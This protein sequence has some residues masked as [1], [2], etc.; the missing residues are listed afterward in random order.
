MNRTKPF[1]TVA[2][3]T[4]A[5]VFAQTLV[6]ATPPAPIT[7]FPA[8]KQQVVSGVNYGNPVPVNSIGAGPVGTLLFLGNNLYG[9]TESGG[10]YGLGTVFSVTTSGTLNW[11]RD[12]TGAVH[13]GA[14]PWT[15][16][17]VSDG[18]WLYGTTSAGGKYGF[19]VVFAL[20][21][22]GQTLNVLH[23]FA[24][25]PS[26]GQQPECSLVLS[27]GWLYGT[28]STGGQY[29]L[30]EY[31]TVFGVSTLGDTSGWWEKNLIGLQA[32]NGT[33]IGSRPGPN[34]V[35]SGNV[36][37][38][39][40]T[41]GD[42]TSTGS[43]EGLG[44]GTVFAISTGGNLMSAYPIPTSVGSGAAIWQSTVD[45][46]GHTILYGTGVKTVFS[47]NASSGNFTPLHTFSG[48]RENGPDGNNPGPLVWGGLPTQSQPSLLVGLANDPSG[49]T[50]GF[51]FEVGTSGS[52]AF[53]YEPFTLNVASNGM[54][55]SL[56][57][58]FPSVYLNGL[59]GSFYDG[60]YGTA[61]A[62]GKNNGS[63]TL[64]Y[65]NLVPR[66][67]IK[68]LVGPGLGPFRFNVF[69][70]DPPGFGLQSA[71]SINGPWTNL[72]VFSG[73]YTNISIDSQ[74][75]F[76]LEGSTSNL[77]NAAPFV[78]T[79]PPVSISPTNA[80]LAGSVVPNG[81]NSVAWFQYGATT[82]YGSMTA[83]T[84]ISASN[85]VFLTNFIA[86]L[87]EGAVCHYQL[88]ASNICGIN[89]GQDM[90]LTVL[91]TAAT[92][93][94]SF[95]DPSNVVLYGTVSP[96]GFGWDCGP[97]FEYG[98]TT[99]Y[100]QTTAEDFVSATNT[101]PVLVTN[102]ISGLIPGTLYHYQ[103]VGFFFIPEPFP[104]PEGYYQANGGDSTFITPAGPPVNQVVPN[105]ETN[106]AGN[107]DSTYPFDIGAGTMRCQQ[108]YAASQFSMV[109][110]GG[111]YITAIAFRLPSGWG[112]FSN[113][114]SAI[115]ID[116][117][118][119]TNAP[120]GLS[121]TFANN[122]GTNDTVV[123]NGPL[124]LSSADVGNPPNF[125][126]VVPLTTPFF[127]NPSA[128]NL[129]LDV[130]NTGDGTTSPFDADSSG[131]F[132]SRAYGDASSGTAEGTDSDGLV[133]EFVFATP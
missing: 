72:N 11:N 103:F 66:L 14:S 22:D 91:P 21:L 1:L 59:T 126:I 98:T 47:F 84:F 95:I 122:V 107:I 113:T 45:S 82:N 49:L 8:T 115:Q 6:M 112:S 108:V 132:M 16:G 125:D 34:F 111:A 116:L 39:N 120:D 25:G 89:T 119:T 67:T 7:T 123:F 87:S 44:N 54:A 52:P 13:D 9:M 70:S 81:A 94:Y 60:Y 55:N 42:G 30:F 92:L 32:P 61:Q 100:G 37:Y 3:L 2:S 124:S 53:F 130:R 69:W 127:Y 41:V 51:V 79:L 121:S 96:D 104:E 57:D 117:S 74:E 31:G 43:S 4:A 78:V 93:S 90:T 27:G 129:L 26:D 71:T 33:Y 28:T 48:S 97:F 58:G 20:S 101:E 35:L 19:G 50:G 102:I 77:F 46:L 64:F 23:S 73:S 40:T 128:G 38:G 56:G 88:V 114:L 63:G 83:T 5:Y 86:G 76:R 99:N 68:P 75:F 133:T 10:S 62:G 131:E 12:F 65:F 118:T 24:S 18:T 85:Q 80:G 29:G 17:L 109:P 105:A 110:A 15:S 106:V 36:L